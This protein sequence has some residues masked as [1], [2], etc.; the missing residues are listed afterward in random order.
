MLDFGL[1]IAMPYTLR[2]IRLYGPGSA[3]GQVFSSSSFFCVRGLKSKMYV[4]APQ[5]KKSD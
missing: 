2:N 1:Q 4:R 3:G 5:L